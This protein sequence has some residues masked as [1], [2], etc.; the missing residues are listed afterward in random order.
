MCSNENDVIIEPFLVSGSVVLSCL[1]FNRQFI[2]FEISKPIFNVAVGRI[3][4][5]KH[6]LKPNKRKID[7]WL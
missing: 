2:G 1:K 7:S 4:E 6:Q 5:M 3:E